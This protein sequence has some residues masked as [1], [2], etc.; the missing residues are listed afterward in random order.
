MLR[1]EYESVKLEE[2]KEIPPFSIVDK[3]DI[4]EKPVRPKKKLN[5]LMGITLGMFIGGFVAFFKE[6]WEKSA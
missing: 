1:K 4:P 5:T 2:A 6:Y 3:P